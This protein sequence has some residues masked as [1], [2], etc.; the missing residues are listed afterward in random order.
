MDQKNILRML[1]FVIPLAAWPLVFVV[2][3]NIFLYSM[4]LS[5]TFLGLVTIL[6]FKNDLMHLL[7]NG[8]D[9]KSKLKS[10]FAGVVSSFV[11]YIIFLLG[12]KVSYYL[13]FENLVLSIYSMILDTNRIT[14]SAVLVIIGMM[15]EI[16]WRG[17]IQGIF[18]NNVEYPWILS[19]IYYSM[20]HIVTFNYVLVIAALIVGLITGYIAYRFGIIPSIIAHI[21]WLELIII[22]FPV[23]P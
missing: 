14:L 15:E 4:G 5:T 6:F 3:K 12:G 23:L 7:I 13:G 20:I 19:S 10:I 1:L 2:L 22:I 18:I 8:Q 9:Q 16:Y 21:I 17:F 11:L